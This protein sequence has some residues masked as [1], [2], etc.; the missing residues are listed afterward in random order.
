MES[1][2]MNRKLWARRELARVMS[3]TEWRAKVRRTGDGDVY[4]LNLRGYYM[5]QSPIVYGVGICLRFPILVLFPVVLPKHIQ[6][7]EAGVFFCLIPILTPNIFWL[8]ET[9]LGL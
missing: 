8:L 4:L 3:T 2:S 1:G 7:F 5:R 6:I 9:V